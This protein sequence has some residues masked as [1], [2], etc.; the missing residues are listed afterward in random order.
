MGH[1][2][3]ITQLTS[4][5]NNININTIHC[6]NDFIIYNTKDAYYSAG[7]NVDGQCALDKNDEN[8]LTYKMIEYFNKINVKVDKIFVNNEGWSVFWQTNNKRIYANGMNSCY[9]LGLNDNKK[10]IKPE[11]VLGLNGM[12]ILQIKN[13]RHH[14][15]ALDANGCVYAAGKKGFCGLINIL[16]N[17]YK[18]GDW[19]FI[20]TLKNVNIIQIQCGWLHSMFL[21]FDGIVYTGGNNR[22][23]Q[24]QHGKEYNN[25]KEEQIQKVKYFTNKKIKIKNIKSGSHHNLVMD[26]NG[27]VYTWGSNDCGQCGIGSKDSK[28]YIPTMVQTKTND[29]IQQIVTGFRHSCVKTVKGGYWLFGWNGNNQVTLCNTNKGNKIYSP[30]YINDIFKEITKGQHIKQIILGRDCTLIISKRNSENEEKK[31]ALNEN[32]P[33]P[34]QNEAYNPSAPVSQPVSSQPTVKYVDQNGNPV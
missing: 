34:M 28:I 18:Y 15:I 9:Q 19:N 10:R 4:L 2:N 6:G 21:S 27:C 5:V 3:N 22:S 16:N 31:N 8:I 12:K 13:G 14:S 26:E 11:I 23:G 20:K 17:E 32:Q 25:N 33:N 1:K 7:Y 30:F 24:L 29:K